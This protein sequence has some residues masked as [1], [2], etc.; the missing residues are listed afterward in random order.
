[1]TEEQKQ[2]WRS[3]AAE[4]KQTTTDG[5]DPTESAWNALKHDGDAQPIVSRILCVLRAHVSEHG[6]AVQEVL[7]ALGLGC[8]D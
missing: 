6:P 5:D 2:R 4:L 7:S 1:M 8:D 3:I